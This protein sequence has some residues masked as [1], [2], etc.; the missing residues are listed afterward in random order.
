M[1]ISIGGSTLTFSDSTTMT[2]A[3]A[4]GPPGRVDPAVQ[5]LLQQVLVV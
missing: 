2:T 5:M 3:A 1:S 4:A